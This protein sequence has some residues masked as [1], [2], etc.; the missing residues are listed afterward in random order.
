MS[1]AFGSILQC[2]TDAHVLLWQEF[3]PAWGATLLAA[4][5]LPRLGL[6]ASFRRHILTTIALP[7]TAFAGMALVLALPL[8]SAEADGEPSTALVFLGA[9]LGTLLGLV[10]AAQFRTEVV[11]RGVAAMIV[12]SLAITEIA[13]SLSPF[14]ETRLEPLL[15]G[16]VLG[17]SAERLGLLSTILLPGLFALV[18]KRRWLFT[19]SCPDAARAAGVSTRSA[20][21]EFAGALGFAVMLATLTL[22]PLLTASLL[23]IPAAWARH[24][25]N[26]VRGALRESTAMALLSA[27]WGPVVSVIADIPLGAGVVMVALVTGALT[28]ALR[29]R[30]AR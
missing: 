28:R 6:H 25:G 11:T 4:L 24:A 17:L 9:A 18:A 30:I 14:G 26:N 22:G 19:A 23:I 7:Q 3:R 12:A 16:E 1:G 29:R 13:R 27:W 10:I 21:F 20:A 15:H 5:V 8:L 2:L